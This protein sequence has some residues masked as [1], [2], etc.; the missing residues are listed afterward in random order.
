MGRS[1]VGE[2]G[3]DGE[4]TELALLGSLAAPGGT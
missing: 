2:E 3:A 4:R 1:Q